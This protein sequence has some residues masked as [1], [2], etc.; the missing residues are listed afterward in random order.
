MVAPTINVAW[1]G[2]GISGIELFSLSL[3]S[4]KETRRAGDVRAR[5]ACC[6][7][8]CTVWTLW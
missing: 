2:P 1:L 3:D 4:L 5:R 8:S 6:E 7:I